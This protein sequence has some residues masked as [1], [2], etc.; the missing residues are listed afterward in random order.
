MERGVLSHPEDCGGGSPERS[1]GPSESA[2]IARPPGRRRCLIG[3]AVSVPVWMAAVMSARPVM[4]LSAISGVSTSP[5]FFNPSIGQREEIRFMVARPGTV[6]VEILDRDRYLIRRLAEQAVQPG[7]ASFLWDGKDDAGL[8]V[9][10]EAY[11]LRIT[12][13]GESAEDAYDPSRQHDP[14]PQDLTSCTYSRGEGIL[15]YTLPWPARVHILAGQATPDPATKAPRGPVLRTVVDRQPRTAGSVVEAW[16]G[17]D[18]SGTI[19]VPD[20]PHFVVGI[21]I[22]PLPENTIIAVGN[23]NLAFF[24]YAQ[25]HRSPD[26]LAPRPLD[27]A[28]H[29]HHV[30]L[31][32]FEDQDPPLRIGVR[33][34]FDP[35]IRAYRAQGKPLDV[36]L[37]IDPRRGVYFLNPN[38]ELSVFVDEKRVLTQKAQQSPSQVTLGAG[39]LPPGQHR[40]AFNWVS[41]F[42]P[43]AVA[44]VTV[45]VAREKSPQ[46]L[47]ER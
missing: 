35:T 21:T 42:G 22:A 19:Y 6:R 7:P 20:L 38:A 3:L 25:R 16:K 44:V 18:E 12:L 26:A 28:R 8:V 15:S 46:D 10:D 17:F 41:G 11:T 24:D 2:A 33:A 40:V 30:G 34:A 5:A 27:V 9:P 13:L 1:H 47:R 23:R 14:S 37:T 45:D 31:T 29:A 36:T 4:L 43:V 32:A 39:A